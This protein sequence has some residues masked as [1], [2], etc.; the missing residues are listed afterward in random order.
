MSS[1]VVLQDLRVKLRTVHQ[2]DSFCWLHETFDSIK[3]FDRTQ[4]TDIS[5]LTTS[6]GGGFTRQAQDGFEDQIFTV[7][8]ARLLPSCPL[9]AHCTL[10]VVELPGECI[11]GPY[12][13]DGTP[14]STQVFPTK[15]NGRLNVVELPQL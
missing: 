3:G 7:T 5:G 14:S 13:R 2:P 10:V 11:P 15:K 8:R 6:L 12:V 9:C 1:L 4:R